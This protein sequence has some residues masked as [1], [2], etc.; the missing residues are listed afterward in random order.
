M[1]DIPTERV[2]FLTVPRESYAYDAN[3][4]RLVEPEAEKLFRRPRKDEP[5]AVARGLPVDSGARHDRTAA[6]PGGVSTQDSA[7]ESDNHNKYGKVRAG[8]GKLP[9]IE[10][11]APARST[12]PVPTFR[13]NTAAEDTCTWLPNAP[14]SKAE[15]KPSELPPGKWGNCPVVWTCNL[16]PPSLD[17]ESAG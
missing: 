5:V 11:G 15:T 12:D 14:T 3:R 7:L 13:G 17:A 16:S 1:R 9:G 6:G 4:D 2:R 10:P 8:G